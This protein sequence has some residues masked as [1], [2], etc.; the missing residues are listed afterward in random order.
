M[1]GRPFSSSAQ[2]FLPLCSKRTPLDYNLLEMSQR[3]IALSLF[4]AFA[5]RDCRSPGG[6][7]PF[8]RSNL[9]AGLL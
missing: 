1:T 5:I 4:F 3:L 2:S 8:R 7:P 6:R 9:T